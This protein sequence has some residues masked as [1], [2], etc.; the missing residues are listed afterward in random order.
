MTSI[1]HRAPLRPTDSEPKRHVRTPEEKRVIHE[2]RVKA[3]K[4]LGLALA[5]TVGVPLA[6]L[7]GV[8]AVEAARE[9]NKP[10]SAPAPGED[11]F[12]V[13]FSPNLMPS[14]IVDAFKTR[15]GMGNRGGRE[16]LTDLLIQEARDYNKAVG[17]GDNNSTIYPGMQFTVPAS[18]YELNPDYQ[19]QHIP[20]QEINPTVQ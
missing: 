20:V 16:K 4:G 15:P 11:A 18:V 6:T 13:Q 10:L 1:S 7:K 2:H 19:G 8:H 5:L 3:A 9:A 17:L 14:E 12:L